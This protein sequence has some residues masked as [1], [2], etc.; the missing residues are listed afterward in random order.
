MCRVYFKSQVIFASLSASE[1]N[2][3]DDAAF[4]GKCLYELFWACFYDAHFLYAGCGWKVSFNNHTRPS[5]PVPL[6][7]KAEFKDGPR[8]LHCP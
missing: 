4:Q 1:S 5:L 2:G 7:G 3:K 8:T 6:L